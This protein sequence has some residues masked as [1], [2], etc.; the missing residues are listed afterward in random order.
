M[1]TLKILT[2]LCLIKPKIKTKNAFVKVVY[3]GFSCENAHLEHKKRFRVN[4][5]WTKCKTKKRNF[6]RQIPVPFTVYADSFAKKY[7]D[8]V[9]CIFA[10][11]VGCIDN[12]FSKDIVL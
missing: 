1:S 6:I 10:Y 8:Q 7:Q 3:N 5:L 2:D 4:K 11:K 12:K 9:P